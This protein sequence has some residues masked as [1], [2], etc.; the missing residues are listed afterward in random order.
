MAW[1]LKGFIFDWTYVP[2]PPKIK[3]KNKKEENCFSSITQYWNLTDL[4]SNFRSAIQQLTTFK[5]SL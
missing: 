3:G 1:P 4:G 2:L 5:V